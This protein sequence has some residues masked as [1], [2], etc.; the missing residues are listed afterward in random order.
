MPEISISGKAEMAHE[1]KLTSN[2][3]AREAKNLAPKSIPTIAA[4]PATYAAKTAAYL[5]Q[6]KHPQ[7]IE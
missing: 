6:Q 2:A 5:S 7:M 1:M 4:V 3:V